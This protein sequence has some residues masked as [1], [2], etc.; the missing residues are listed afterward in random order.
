MKSLLKAAYWLWSHCYDTA[1]DALFGFDRKAAIDALEIRKGDKILELGVGTGLNIPFY[2]SGCTV[3]GVDLSR[4]M[5][6]KAERKQ[7][8]AQVRLVEADAEDLP[9][10][11]NSFDCGLAT[12]LFR[13]T[14]DPIKALWE[15]TRVIRPQGRLVIADHVGR[16]S[17]LDFFTAM[18]GWGR[19]L[20]LK[21]LAMQAGWRIAKDVQLGKSKRTRLLVLVHPT[22]REKGKTSSPEK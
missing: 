20:P 11:S 17:V 9:F 10:R 14:P 3:T 2:P 6:A 1:I 22:D 15:A 18:I 8:K 7:R 16:R 12:F 19:D 5:I 13:V 4:Q 21:D